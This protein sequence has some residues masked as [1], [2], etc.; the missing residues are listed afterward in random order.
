LFIETNPIAIKWA[1][2]RMGLM[3]NEL[4]LPLTR[5]SKKHYEALEKVLKSLELI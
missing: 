3:A 4:R 2:S 1:A 5:L